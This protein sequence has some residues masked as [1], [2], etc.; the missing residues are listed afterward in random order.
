MGGYILSDLAIGTYAWIKRGQA[1]L[2][3]FEWFIIGLTS[4][5]ACIYIWCRYKQNFKPAV[6]VN[7]I[8][9]FIS[10][11]PVVVETYEQPRQMS[12]TICGMYLLVSALAYY[13]EEKFSGKFI[14]GLSLIYWTIVI[15]IMVILR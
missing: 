6:I 7:G 11:A 14:P 9:C 2:G 1:S 13:G 8:A 3:P 15:S 10:G 4:V 5:C 12:Y